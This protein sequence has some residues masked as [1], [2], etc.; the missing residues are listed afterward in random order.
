MENEKKKKGL[1]DNTKL[2]IILAAVLLVMGAV[3]MVLQMTETDGKEEEGTNKPEATEPQSPSSSAPVTSTSSKIIDRSSGDIKSVEITADTGENFTITYSAENGNQTSSMS[4]ENVLKYSVDE[5]NTLSGYVGL[6]VAVEDVGENDD[7]SLFGLDKPRR[8]LR[9]TFK[10]GGEQTLLLGSETPYVIGTARGV[11]AKLSG[12][13][14]IYTIGGSTSEILMRT[15]AEYREIMIFETPSDAG[16]FE[17]VTILRSGKPALKIVK[18]DESEKEIAEDP[19]LEAYIPD[20]KI[21]SPIERNTDSYALE[22][23]IFGQLLNLKSAK[24]VEDYPKNL[25]EYG[26]DNPVKLS[27]KT[28]YGG[29]NTLLIGRKTKSGGRYV[30]EDGVPSVGEIDFDLDLTTVGYADIAEKLIWFFNSTDSPVF[31]YELAN[32]EKHT[33]K[34]WSE[35]KSLKSLYDGAALTGDNGKN[36]F[37]NTVGMALAGEC[38]SG[39]KLGSRVIKIKATLG[40][41]ETSTLELFPINDRQYA[42]KIDGKAPQFYV[43]IDTVQALLNCFDIIKNGGTIPDVL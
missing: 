24:I 22:E 7:D 4:G 40:N 13:N 30:M 8:T 35:N 16:D 2:L 26:L 29:A 18:R 33:L 6:L 34:V 25:S 27:F 41:G 31:E 17:E 38:E 9:I 21:V 32:G 37:F 28:A 15:K 5:M 1:A 20:Y 39:A 10:D 19:S 3:F 14:H 42:V 12:S 36:L 23:K 43:G 11:Y